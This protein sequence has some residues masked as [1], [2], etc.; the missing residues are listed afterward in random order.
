LEQ[1]VAA[2]QNRLDLGVGEELSQALLQSWK[3]QGLEIVQK[4]GPHGSAALGQ[5][6]REILLDGEGDSIVREHDPAGN[7]Q[8][9]LALPDSVL[10]MKSNQAGKRPSPGDLR[11]HSSKHAEAVVLL[12]LF[13]IQ[14]PLDLDLDRPLGA[15]YF[16]QHGDGHQV[17]AQLTVELVGRHLMLV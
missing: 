2:S 14:G 13:E 15:I 3:L 11:T 6:F 12:D 8:D 10:D 5:I 4:R 1:V 9:Q 7:G 16:A 17:Q